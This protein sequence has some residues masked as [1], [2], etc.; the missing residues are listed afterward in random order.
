MAHTSRA[1]YTNP[2]SDTNALTADIHPDTCS[3][4]TYTANDVNTDPSHTR[5]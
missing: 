4:D 2:V 3:A 5:Y 1:I